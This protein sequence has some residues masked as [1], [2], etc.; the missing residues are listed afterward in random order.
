MADDHGV[1]SVSFYLDSNHN[2]V[3]DPT[4]LLGTSTSGW[5]WTGAVTWGTGIQTYLAIATDD[6]YP[7]GGPLRQHLGLRDE[8]GSCHHLAADYAG[9]LQ[10]QCQPSRPGAFPSM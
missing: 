2:G 6:G 4:E 5:T 3:G 10:S 9:N 7:A 8:H 1:A